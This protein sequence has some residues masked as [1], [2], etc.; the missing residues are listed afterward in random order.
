MEFLIGVVLV[1]ILLVVAWR[2]NKI[3]KELK[4]LNESLERSAART[5]V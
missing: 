3:H 2:L 5:G 1:L 4:R